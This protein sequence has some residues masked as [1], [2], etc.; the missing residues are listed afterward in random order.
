MSRAHIPSAGV[1]VE[2]AQRQRWLEEQVQE[3]T[4][5]VAALESKLGDLHATDVSSLRRAYKS[6]AQHVQALNI[7]SKVEGLRTGAA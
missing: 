3:L 1:P 2:P 4:Q 5:E 7:E 6:L